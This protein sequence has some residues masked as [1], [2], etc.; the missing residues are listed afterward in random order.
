MAHDPQKKADV[1]TDW[2]RGKDSYSTLSR[3]HG[4][5]KTTIQEWIEAFQTDQN[6]SIV[7]P[8]F[9]RFM[10]ALENFGVATMDMLTAQAE[11]LSD[12]NYLINKDTSDV[13]KHTE[14]IHTGLQRFVQLF[15]SVQPTQDYDALPASTDDALVPELVEEDS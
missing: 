15:R 6:R 13:I 3:R 2:L 9:N 4:V 8:K 14:A 10:E 7:E 1:I 12:K 5:P 11:L